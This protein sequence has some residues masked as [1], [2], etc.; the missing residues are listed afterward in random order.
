M[1]EREELFRAVALMAAG[2]WL[3]DNHRLRTSG[4]RLEERDDLAAD[5]GKAGAK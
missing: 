1:N 5:A 2:M 4:A 3:A